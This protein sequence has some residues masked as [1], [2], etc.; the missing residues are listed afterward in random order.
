[1]RIYRI[2]PNYRL[3]YKALIILTNFL[4]GLVSVLTLGLFAT[5]LEM[6]VHSAGMR[7]KIKQLKIQRDSEAAKEK[8]ND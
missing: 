7:D 6:D 4:D 2:N 3:R 1:M 5:S 8:I